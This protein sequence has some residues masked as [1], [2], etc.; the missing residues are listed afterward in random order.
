ML[1]FTAKK[2][3]NSSIYKSLLFRHQSTKP[4]IRLNAFLS[5]SAF[6]SSTSLQ[7][8]PK[9]DA[10]TQS[11]LVNSCGVSVDSAKRISNYLLLKSAEKPSRTLNFFKTNSFTDAQISRIVTQAPNV[12]LADPIKTLKPKFDYFASLGAPQETVVKI[13]CNCPRILKISVDNKIA[14]VLDCLKSVG[15]SNEEVIGLLALSK[16]MMAPAR[17]LERNFA[18]LEKF[19]MSSLQIWRFVLLNTRS[20]VTPPSRFKEMAEKALAMGFDPRKHNFGDAINSFTIVAEDLWEQKV[21]NFKKLGWSDSEFLMAFKKQPRI[22]TLSEKKIKRTMDY[23]VSTMG[24][25]VSVIARCPNVLHYSLE[26]RIIPRCSVLQVLISKGLIE[27]NGITISSVLVRADEVFLLLFVKKYEEVQD[28]LMNMY[29]RL[30][31]EAILE[32]TSY[33]Q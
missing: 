23:L 24:L 11:F 22:M 33:A 15:G 14:P 17:Y 9:G 13:I 27:K 4:L 20:S 28:E 3:L 31:K 8:D 21:N 5:S 29:S 32:S 26:K 19:G 1:G 12:L 25:N 2:L 16:L 30:K 7:P 6:N 18:V 10:F